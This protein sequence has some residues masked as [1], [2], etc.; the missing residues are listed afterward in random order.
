[1][2]KTRRRGDTKREFSLIRQAPLG[3][4]EMLLFTLRLTYLLFRSP[5]LWCQYVR[6][7]HLEGYYNPRSFTQALLLRLGRNARF[8]DLDPLKPKSVARTIKQLRN[9]QACREHL[10]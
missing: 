10:T 4:V 9:Q 6:A 5:A 2:P 7:M 1:M 3:R 8:Y